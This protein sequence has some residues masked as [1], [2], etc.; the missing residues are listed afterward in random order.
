MDMDIVIRWSCKLARN[1]VSTCCPDLADDV[2][3]AIYYFNLSSFFPNVRSS[4]CRFVIYKGTSPVQLS[5]VGRPSH[6]IM[7]LADRTM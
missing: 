4:M 5:H 6:R 1:K 3:P 2:I 7:A